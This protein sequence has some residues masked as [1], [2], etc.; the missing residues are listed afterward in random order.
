MAKKPDAA[1]AAP[2]ANKYRDGDT[3]QASE[4]L[5]R[6]AEGESTSARTERGEGADRLRSG[7]PIGVSASAIR[8]CGHLQVQ[9]SAVGR[10]EQERSAGDFPPKRKKI[11]GGRNE[12]N[13]RKEMERTATICAER[14]VRVQRQNI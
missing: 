8:P 14:T 11:T 2:K 1:E 9:E 6:G 3:Q 7:D 4:E 10:Q 13:D 5:R 12:K